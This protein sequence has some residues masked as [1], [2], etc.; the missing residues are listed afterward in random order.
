MAGATNPGSIE[1]ILRGLLRDMIEVDGRGARGDK[2]ARVHGYVDGYMRA[3]VDLGIASPK[4]LLEIVLDERRRAAELP[5]GRRV[6]PE[7][8]RIE[9]AAA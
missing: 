6:G 2:L 7:R 1:H 8:A 4:E 9:S 5:A 3:L